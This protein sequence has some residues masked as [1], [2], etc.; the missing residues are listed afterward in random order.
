MTAFGPSHKLVRPEPDEAD[1]AFRSVILRQQKG[2]H[3]RIKWLLPEARHI[4][5]PFFSLHFS[6]QFLLQTK[7]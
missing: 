7:L 1:Y 3:A 2:S 4:R 5:Q 6:A